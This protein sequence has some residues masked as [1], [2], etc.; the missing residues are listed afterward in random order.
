DIPADDITTDL[1][2]DELLEE[3]Y[4]ILDAAQTAAKKKRRDLKNAADPSGK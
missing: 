2:L 4:S 1:L 3:D